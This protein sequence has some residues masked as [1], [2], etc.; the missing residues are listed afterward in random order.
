[1]YFL[2][3]KV[4]NC[5][6]FVRV[7]QHKIGEGGGGR[8]IKS[9]PCLPASPACLPGWLLLRDEIL[10]HIMIGHAGYGGRVGVTSF[11]L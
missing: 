4:D 6:L 7:Q 11:G 8:G 10:R 9:T 1:M 5:W 2:V 3:V